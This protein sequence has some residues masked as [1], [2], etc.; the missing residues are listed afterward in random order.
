LEPS[1]LLRRGQVPAGA[2]LVGLLFGLPSLAIGPAGDDWFYAN[3]LFEFPWQHLV[4][5]GTFWRPLDHIVYWLVGFAHGWHVQA[6]HLAALLGHAAS[7]A[8]LCILLQEIGIGRLATLVAAFFVAV[9]PA[10]TAA[11]WSVDSNNQTWSTAFGLFACL[12]ALR[13]RNPSWVV[14][15]MIAALWK[16]S[17]VGWFAAVPTLR[18]MVSAYREGVPLS[19]LRARVWAE[20]S[21]FAAGLA[22]AAVYFSARFALVGQVSLGASGGRY[23]LSH[24]P[25]VWVKNAALL[26][27]VV[28]VP[29]NTVSILGRA[30]RVAA[31]LAP[32]LL[33]LPFLVLAARE[34]ARNTI[35][36][37]LWPWL[38]C[39]VLLSVMA[40]HIFISHVS[41][42]HAHPLAFATA[43]PLCLLLAK[44]P[45]MSVR[46]TILL[47]V[48]VLLALLFVDVSKYREMLATG[49][50][51]K[52][53]ARQNSASLERYRANGICFLREDGD[54]WGGGYSVYQMDAGLA[55]GWGKAMVL[56]WGWDK[57]DAIV[58]DRLPTECP[59]NLPR[60]R[61]G[62]DGSLRSVE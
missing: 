6:C 39:M 28:V 41:E 58:V 11:V 2:A 45:H 55:A 50:L 23:A 7:L 53:F 38:T 22:G 35:R 19:Q 33:A 54:Q 3:P 24:N 27:G 5:F 30:H 36:R 60:F 25:L 49:R 51:G 9:H 15:A 31:G 17:G 12:L 34:L 29:A 52:T 61:V 20:R 18:L 8:L 37:A 10:T 26:L 44:R 42:M 46:S 21:W 32:A 4:P 62:R 43:V 59:A 48:P 14:A 1:N 40:P 16:E 47:L 13:K 57:Y 56:D